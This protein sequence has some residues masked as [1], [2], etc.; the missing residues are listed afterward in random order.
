MP[1]GEIS[2]IFGIS[3]DITERKEMEIALRA[4]E[5]RFHSLFNK[6]ARWIRLCRMWYEDGIPKDFMYLDVQPFL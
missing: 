4:S 3:R 5:N 1:A 2:G 6:H